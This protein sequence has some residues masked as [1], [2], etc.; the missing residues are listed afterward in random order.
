MKMRVRSI[1]FTA[2]AEETIRA[3]AEQAGEDFA[4]YVRNAAY[5]RAVY[6]LATPVKGGPLGWITEDGRTDQ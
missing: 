1:R 6:A 2:D 4:E 5:A 3:A